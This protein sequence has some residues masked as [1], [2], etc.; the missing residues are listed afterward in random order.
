MMHTI[1]FKVNIC[2][3]LS[4]IVCKYFFARAIRCKWPRGCL[5][6]WHDTQKSTPIPI[7]INNV[8][9]RSVLRTTK[10]PTIIWWIELTYI[11]QTNG[12]ISVVR[13]GWL[14]FECKSMLRCGGGGGGG[15]GD[16]FPHAV[17]FSLDVIFNFLFWVFVLFTCIVTKQNKTKFPLQPT[18]CMIKNFSSAI[19]YYVVFVRCN[20]IRSLFMCF[21]DDIHIFLH[22]NYFQ[23]LCFFRLFF[24]EPKDSIELGNESHQFLLQ[25]VFMTYL[26]IIKRS[27]RM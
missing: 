9:R 23:G 11:I 16:C 10:A 3:A 2:S 26:S 17:T 19:L 6:A 14:P 20:C 21:Y 13:L 15:C 7:D 25:S 1:H 18:K 24:E 8:P 5:G 4:L 22:N 27:I 12:M